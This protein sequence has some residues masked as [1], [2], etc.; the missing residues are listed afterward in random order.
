MQ[1]TVT[2]QYVNAP[3]QGKKYGSIKMQDGS[4]FPVPGHLIHNFAKGMATTIEYEQQNW[5]DGM[6]D[7]VTN[8]VGGD[9]PAPQQA[10]QAAQQA[11]APPAQMAPQSDQAEDIFVTGVVGRAMGS[12]AFTATDVS[13][14]TKAA[15][16]A[17]RSRHQTTFPANSNA[18]SGAMAG[19]GDPGP[20]S[21]N[22]YGYNP[23]HEQTG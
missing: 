22:D 7:V 20:Q 6:V 2:P 15:I 8:V 9:A 18:H 4:R 23:P 12:G 3:K 17:W 5:G 1:T 19:G 21:P 13:L 14:L 16:E 10:G 11:F